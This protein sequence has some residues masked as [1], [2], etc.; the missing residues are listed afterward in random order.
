MGKLDAGRLS[1]NKV[2]F[3]YNL[4]QGLSTVDQSKQ[5]KYQKGAG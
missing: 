2:Y 1:S 5:V 3:L 4:K